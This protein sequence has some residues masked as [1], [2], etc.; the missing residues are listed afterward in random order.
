MTFVDVLLIGGRAGVR[1]S[2]LGWAVSELLLGTLR[3]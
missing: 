3:R 2:T 1:R